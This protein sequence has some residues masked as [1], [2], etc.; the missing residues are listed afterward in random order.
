MQ[1]DSNTLSQL[2]LPTQDSSSDES[3]TSVLLFGSSRRNS[4]ADDDIGYGFTQEEKA[5][6][7][8]VF[9][10]EDTKMPAKKVTPSQ[11]SRD[12]DSLVD[13]DTPT[14]AATSAPRD[15]SDYA[16][17]TPNAPIKNVTNA[18]TIGIMSNATTPKVSVPNDDFSTPLNNNTT[19][20]SSS[21]RVSTPVAR[22]K[23]PSPPSVKA[24]RSIKKE[25][26]KVEL[27]DSSDDEVIFLGTSNFGWK[28]TSHAAIKRAK[29]NAR[30]KKQRKNTYNGRANIVI[31]PP[32]QR[33]QVPDSEEYVNIPTGMP[34]AAPTPAEKEDFIERLHIAEIT[35]R[36]AIRMLKENKKGKY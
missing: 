28:S 2:Y 3:D 30:Y 13:D 23:N 22:K 14:A 36:D 26:K 33:V 4:G 31:S 27:V 5:A 17:K 7:A 10:Q 1:N 20:S 24:T 8:A 35:I 9:T 11:A 12:D 34:V 15:M 16:V 32:Y 21:R 18:P 29:K 19:P 25:S 6:R